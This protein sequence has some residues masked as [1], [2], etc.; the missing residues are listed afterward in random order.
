MAVRVAMATRP[1]AAIPTI[2]A[3]PPTVLPPLVPAIPPVV[4]TVAAVV[5]AVAPMVAA[6]VAAIAPMSA[7]VVA[8]VAAPSHA[9]DMLASGGS[10][11]PVLPA[12]LLVRPPARLAEGVV[13]VQIGGKAQ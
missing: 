12:G 6:V 11:A 9:G 2:P 4:P 8:A 3:A 7:A 1:G 10:V 5:A 13:A